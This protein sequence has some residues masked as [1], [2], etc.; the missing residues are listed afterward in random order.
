[1]TK[2]EFG[3]KIYHLFELC[4]TFHRNLQSILNNNVLSIPCHF[5]IIKQIYELTHL[6]TVTDLIQNL[7]RDLKKTHFNVGQI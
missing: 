2:D 4:L 3:D 6:L 5:D 1:M 7:K